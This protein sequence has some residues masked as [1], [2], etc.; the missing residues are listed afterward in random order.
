VIRLGLRLSWGA[1]KEG[2]V[3][4]VLTAL[5]VALAV[6]LLLFTISGFNALDAKDVRGGWLDTSRANRVP[7]VDESRSDPL[8]WRLSYDLYG[9]RLMGLVEVAATGP[10]S[11][12]VPGLDR[13][14]GPGEY[15][16]SR[17]LAKLLAATPADQL[18]A[19]FSGV[20]A[21]I[22]GDEGLTSPE[23]LMAVV[24]R[25]PAELESSMEAFQVRSIETAPTEHNYSEFVKVALGIG[26]VGLMLPVLVFVMTSTRLAAARREERLAAL[27]LVGATPGQVSIVAAVE[28]VLAAI[29]GTA[30]GFGLFYVFR[31]LVARIPFTG[32][33]FFTTDLSL[34]P[35][36]IA[37]V[38]I[39]VPVASVLASLWTLRRVQ[40]SPLGVT[41]KAP[42]R[43]PRPIRLLALVVAV[44]LL[45]VP[46][47]I[48][49][50]QMRTFSV[51]VVF[52]VIAL[53]IMVVG[54]WLTSAGS[55]VL[56]ALARRDSTLIA[57]RRLGSDSRRAF[58]AISGLVLA[59]FI[60]TVFTSIIAT[61]IDSG[62]G[63]FRTPDLPGSTVVQAFG[64]S[65]EI[66][67]GPGGAI[68]SGGPGGYLQA[69]A[70]S[71]L[72]AKLAV[73]EGVQAVIPVLS[74]PASAA[75][76]AADWIGLVTERDWALLGGLSGQIDTAG[77]VALD[78]GLLAMGF[79]EAADPEAMDEAVAA[80][81]PA[82][83]TETAPAPDE[84]STTKHLI[85]LTD[86]SL[87]SIERVRTALEVAD[88]RQPMPY[89]VA[90]FWAD[91]DALFNALRRMVDV[92]MVL[93][94]VIAGCSLAVSVAGG[95]VERKRAFALL[96]LTG[97]PLRRLYRAVLL[98][99]AVPLLLAAVVSAGVGFLV[100]AL[101]FWN[102]DGGFAV[103]APGV[104]YFALL[105]GGLVAALAIV[106]ATL[107]LVG[108][109]T[110]P[111]TVR[112][113]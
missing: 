75:G 59:V 62:S 56:A 53:A 76:S 69:G 23:T 6:T 103:A 86:G 3:R 9:G 31:P 30:A 8:W 25:S 95:L 81:M 26:A 92:G 38:A 87:A 79:L 34:G 104:G 71:D 15:Y 77:Y 45:L 112:V 1:A 33:P 78:A 17:D 85:I 49:D 14:P 74:L 68:S 93:C 4:L 58:R 107:P 82:G 32:E 43:R 16:V 28:A 7:S 102:T 54:P 89:A 98:E 44:A 106:G 109:M 60:G 63:T 64:G 83:V 36:A 51:L 52:A 47:L 39:G 35:L 80:E 61:A 2:K 22:L 48:D 19:R 24:G 73:T 55:R 42:P 110:E 11:P 40:I 50:S 13:L 67:G 41:R 105:I 100:S 65:P 101:I 46:A 10:A 91:E 37:G 5:G 12:L 66:G 90:E 94:L 57:A 84:S 97:M 70:S 113:E 20:Q 108:K 96:R 18:G 111:Q 21:G 99:A 88:P 72:V 27:R 29:A